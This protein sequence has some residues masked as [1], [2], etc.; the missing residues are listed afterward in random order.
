MY[1]G[2]NFLKNK[3][4]QDAMRVGYSFDFETTGVRAKNRTSH[5]IMISYMIPNIFG[6]A[7]PPVRTP[8]YRHEN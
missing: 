2:I 7:P 3:Q 4:N 6:Q 5:E 8:R 1:V